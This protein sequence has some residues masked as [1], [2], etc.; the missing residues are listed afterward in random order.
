M[1]EW[2]EYKLGENDNQR[3]KKRPKNIGYL[4]EIIMCDYVISLFS[5]I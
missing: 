3:A 1:T 2:K 5:M 4:T